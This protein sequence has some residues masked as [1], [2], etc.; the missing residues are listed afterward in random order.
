MTESG[1]VAEANTES[2]E[3]AAKEKKSMRV[4]IRENSWFGKK[5]LKIFKVFTNTFAMTF[6]AE[7]GDRLLLI[8]F[9][10]SLPVRLIGC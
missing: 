3:E 9:I 6:L 8:F 5:C 4:Q 7:W 1:Q 10:I 2:L